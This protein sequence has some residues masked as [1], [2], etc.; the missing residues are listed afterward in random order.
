MASM[1]LKFLKLSDLKVVPNRQKPVYVFIEA[2]KGSIVDSQDAHAN[3]SN[4]GFSAL[5]DKKT[6]NISKAN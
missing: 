4:S 2:Y 6:M 5:L 1:K 3:H